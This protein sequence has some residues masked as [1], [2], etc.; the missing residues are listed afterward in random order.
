MK[1][2]KEYFVL[3]TSRLKQFLAWVS[4]KVKST[5]QEKWLWLMIVDTN[6]QSCKLHF[7]LALNGITKD[8]KVW[9]KL[10]SLNLIYRVR[11][12]RTPTFYLFSALLDC[13]LWSFLTKFRP[14]ILQFFDQFSAK[15]TIV[16]PK[17]VSWRSNQEW[18]S[19]GADTVV[20][21]ISI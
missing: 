7:K 5:F 1:S 18:H 16:H 10:K 17:L 2:Q 14:K 8:E 21:L 9:I 12:N 15:L 20:R 19:I 11:A 3:L 6:K 13:A 4:L